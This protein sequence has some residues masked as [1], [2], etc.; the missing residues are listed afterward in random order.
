MKKYLVCVLFLLAFAVPRMAQAQCVSNVPDVVRLGESYC[1]TVC[2]DDFFYSFI[3]EGLDRD[4]AGIPIFTL[5][6]GCNYHENG[7]NENCT[8]IAVP[9]DGQEIVWSGPYEDPFAGLVYWANG[10]CIELQTYLNHDSVWVVEIVTYC[11]GCF[12]FTFDRQLP[13][14][15]AGFDASI[16]DNQVTLNWTTASE[17]DIDRYEILRDGRQID[18]VNSLG[19]STVSQS[20]S[21]IDNNVVNGTS[22]SYSLV[23]ID[24]NGQRDVLRTLDGVTPALGAGQVNSY[25]LHQNYPNPFNPSTQI[26]Y[27]MKEAGHVS[28]KV[29]NLIGQEVATLVNGQVAAGRHVANFNGASLASGVYMYKMST[30]GFNAVQ[31]TENHF[32][33]D[34]HEHSFTTHQHCHPR[35]A[36]AGL[37]HALRHHAKSAR[38]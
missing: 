1:I 31:K 8:P 9:F 4:E 18:H 7:C 29:Y 37:R 12:C 22:Y 14:E 15:L 17:A 27:D 20:Y 38:R 21:W 13:V 6:S 16:G 34:S 35:A 25:A 32:A 10:D 24:I 33:G 23:A 5:R 19:S 30:N 11:S 2:E 36:A 28:L 3:V 26:S